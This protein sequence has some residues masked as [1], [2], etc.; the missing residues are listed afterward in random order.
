MF[1]LIQWNEDLHFIYEID[2]NEIESIINHC[3]WWS[4]QRSNQ[5]KQ[6]ARIGYIYV[7]FCCFKAMWAYFLDECARIDDKKLHACN[8]WRCF[9]LC[10]L[11]WSKWNNWLDNFVKLLKYTINV[12]VSSW[13]KTEQS[14][15]LSREMMCEKSSFFSL[16]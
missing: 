14:T 2:I 4:K 15:F 16:K 11:T 8:Y 1:Y 10:I 6:M 5:L 13:I 3:G 9:C 12:L 7:C